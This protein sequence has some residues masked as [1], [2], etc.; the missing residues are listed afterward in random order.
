MNEL[1]TSAGGD[2]TWEQEI[3][4]REAEACAAFL[5]ADLPALEALWADG[6]VVNSPL[7]QV[8]EKQRVLGLLQAGRIRHSSYEYEIEHISRHGDVAVVMGND[9]VADPPD[10]IVSMRRFTNV[11]RLE[12]GRWRSIARHA[13]VVS[14]EAR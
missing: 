6:Y 11:W 12:N 14:R 13:H 3:R 5:A 4:A 1:R 8:L 7:Q 2:S 10:G 9:R